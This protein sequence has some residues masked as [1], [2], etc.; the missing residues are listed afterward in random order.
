LQTCTAFVFPSQEEGIARVQIEA[1]ASGLPLIATHESG[2]TTLVEDGVEGF[3]VKGR[4][5]K[6]IAAA[7]IRCA[8]PELNRQ[9]GEAAYR[10]GAMQ[11]S[12]DDYGDR[13]LKAYENRLTQRSESSRPLATA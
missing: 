11:N 3:I 9:M 5:P 10:K 4:E 7:M 1:L 13:L 8:D 6:D 12:W 2:A